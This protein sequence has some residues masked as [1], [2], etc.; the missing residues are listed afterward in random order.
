[1]L[2]VTRLSLNAGKKRLLHDVSFD[3]EPGTITAIMGPNGA[4]KTSLLKVL[5]NEH[6]NFQGAVD[7]NH[8]P[9]LEW[10]NEQRAKF[11]GVLP[12]YST[13]TFPFTVAE[14]VS[15]GRIAHTSSAK[16]NARIV[17]Q[18]LAA[19]AA[20]SLSDRLYIE[21]SGGEKQRVQLARVMAQIW[22]PVVIAGKELTR[23]LILDEPSSAFD[24]AHQQMLKTQVSE[25]ARNGVTVIIVVHDFNLC[26]ALADQLL[27]LRD[28]GLYARGTPEQLIQPETIESVFEVP[29]QVVTNP[30]DGS[31][32]V[33]V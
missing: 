22:E 20:T 12:Q 8:L 9:L 16:N 3:C 4:G 14:V 29:A 28:G 33:V 15:L 30:K 23:F 2:T 10:P 6:R 13:L 21:L 24:L 18:S 11:I 31:P 27:L 25:F 19:V 1:M 17:Q 26:S 7:V 5:A 32:L